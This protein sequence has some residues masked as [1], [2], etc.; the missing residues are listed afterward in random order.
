MSCLPPEYLEKVGNKFEK[1][2]KKEEIFALYPPKRIAF[3]GI[4]GK[5]FRIDK[6]VKVPND[7]CVVSDGVFLVSEVEE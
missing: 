6:E 5:L 7:I 3:S 2:I 4:F 1:A